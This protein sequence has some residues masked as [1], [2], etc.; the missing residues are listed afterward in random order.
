MAA[1]RSGNIRAQLICAWCVV[2][3]TLCF[4]VGLIAANFLIPVAPSKSAVEIAALY[5]EHTTAIRIGALLCFAG[6]VPFILWG[7]AII[8]QARRIENG[9][10]A[11]AY[12]Q[13]AS[14]AIAVMIVLVP[15]IFFFVAAYRPERFPEITQ[16]LND[17]GWTMFV[18]SFP[19]FMA[20]PIALAIGILG[21]KSEN[22]VFPRWAAYFNIYVSLVYIPPALL[23]FFKTGVFA[24]NGLLSWYVPV[25]D[26]FIWA[27]GMTVLTVRAIRRQEALADLDS[28]P[29]TTG[30]ALTA[31]SAS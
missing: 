9:P 3:F 2:P 10:A 5:Q 15:M 1:T 28:D 25:A 20:W 4:F 6:C 22:P 24:W 16:T 21:D 12:T 19:P 30:P 18:I 11:L 26:F 23:I 7:G 29:T 14:L 27:V 31:R 8:A 17:L 13:V